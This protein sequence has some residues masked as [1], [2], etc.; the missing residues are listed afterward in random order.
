MKGRYDVLNERKRRREASRKCRHQPPPNGFRTHGRESEPRLWR[1]HS[2]SAA[3]RIVAVVLRTICCGIPRT[4][5]GATQVE[6][7]RTRTRRQAQATANDWPWCAVRTALQTDESSLILFCVFAVRTQG[8]YKE[9]MDD[10]GKC[11][12]LYFHPSNSS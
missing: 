11:M 5:G 3:S 7:P 12:C 6:A 10:Q 4:T 1:T 9:E 2:K 8:G